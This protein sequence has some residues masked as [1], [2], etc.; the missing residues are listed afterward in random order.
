MAPAAMSTTSLESAFDIG[1]RLA[2]LLEQAEQD[3]I[4]GELPEHVRDRIAD[5]VESL[6]RRLA[7]NPE[8]D[9]RSL[10]DLDDRLI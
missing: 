3:T 10:V 4:G 2:G 7:R 5:L 6:R 9:P 1:K 8:R